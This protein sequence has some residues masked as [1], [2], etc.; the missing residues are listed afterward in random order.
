VPEYILRIAAAASALDLLSRLAFERSVDVEYPEMRER[1]IALLRDTNDPDAETKWAR[2]WFDD[3][4]NDLDWL[5]SEDLA[6]SIG[7]VL[8]DKGEAKAI[9]AFRERL[10]AMFEDLRDAGYAAYRSDPRWPGVQKAARDAI[11]VIESPGT[12]TG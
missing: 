10:N 11:A 2:G 9:G 12:S 3:W 4:F 1:L 6:E 8:T 5:A 7:V